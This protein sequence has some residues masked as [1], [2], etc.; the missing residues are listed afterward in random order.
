ME[1]DKSRE[2][3]R[4]YGL[5]SRQILGFRTIFSAWLLTK[6]T[7]AA[8]QKGLVKENNRQDSCFYRPV[9]AYEKQMCK[10]LLLFHNI[11]W[12]IM[13]CF[14]SCRS[15]RMVLSNWPWIVS[16]ASK[17]HCIFIC[18]SHF[19]VAGR[20]CARHCKTIIVSLR[21]L[22]E[23]GAESYNNPWGTHPQTYSLSRPIAHALYLV[24][25]SQI[26]GAV[27]IWAEMQISTART[28]Q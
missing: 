22:R 13:N 18:K 19:I 14:H 5:S 23:H 16:R 20:H 1:Q 2:L 8:E 3:C 21:Q 7:I 26:G 15:Q 6:L 17:F 28:L 4:L 9:S 27:R 12:I 10:E 11:R 25:F 24:G